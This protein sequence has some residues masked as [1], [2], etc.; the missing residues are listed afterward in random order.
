MVLQQTC[1]LVFVSAHGVQPK[2]RNSVV[3]A[4]IS[5]CG[6]ACE[7]ELKVPVL[8]IFPAAS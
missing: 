3:L 8:M 4:L 5:A 7:Y 6:G 2:V 1:Q